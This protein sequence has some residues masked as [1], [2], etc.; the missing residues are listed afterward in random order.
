[1]PTPH[2]SEELGDWIRAIGR[3]KSRHRQIKDLITGLEEVLRR[4]E[5]VIE[6]ALWRRAT[7]NNQAQYREADDALSEALAMAQRDHEDALRTL[8]DLF[9]KLD[10]TPIGELFE[11]PPKINVS[12]ASRDRVDEASRESFPASD[13]PAF[14]PGRA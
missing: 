5:E 2:R 6:E 14:N 7:A 3:W 9:K 11:E 12:S 8:A 10:A 13:P 1:M 4:R